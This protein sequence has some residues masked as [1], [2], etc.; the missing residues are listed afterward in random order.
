VIL[1][2]RIQSILNGGRIQSR[3]VEAPVDR[4]PS[5]NPHSQTSTRVLL[6]LSRSLRSDGLTLDSKIV[7]RP[8]PRAEGWNMLD[9]KMRVKVVVLDRKIQTGAKVVV[10]DRKIQVNPSLGSNVIL[11]RKMTMSVPQGRWKIPL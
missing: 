5:V 9:R 6:P 4:H 10:L 1:A 7:S 8:G 2:R 3:G 11:V